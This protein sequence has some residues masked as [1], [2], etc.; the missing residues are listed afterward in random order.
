MPKALVE[1]GGKPMLQWVAEKLAAAGATTIVINM[2]HHA[3]KIREF[4]GG[5]RLPGVEVILS[6]ETNLLL[7]TGGGLKKAAGLLKGDGPVILHNADVLSDIDLRQMLR[8]HQERQAMVTL[9]VSDRPSSRF[10]LWDGNGRLAGWKHT[11]TGETILCGLHGE[12]RYG[13]LDEVQ[14]TKPL[15]PLAFSGVH[16]INPDLPEHIT[17]TGAFPVIDVYLRLA[18]TRRIVCFE[19]DPKYWVDIGNPEKLKHAGELFSSDPERFK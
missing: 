19:H 17:E 13:K 3:G 11:G 7:D 12:S 4:S 10:F 14:D 16:I 1:V 5:L 9:A 6:D 18:A 8:H 15:K 2:H